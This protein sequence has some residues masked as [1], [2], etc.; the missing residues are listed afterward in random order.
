MS[1]PEQW[2]RVA[3]EDAARCR[4][5]PVMAPENSLPPF[6]IY[7]RNGTVRERV[8]VDRCRVPVATF[9]VWIH[10]ETYLE[11]K[12][13]ADEIRLGLDNFKGE[14]GGVTIQRAFLADEM[15]GEPVDFAGEGKPTYTV[16]MLFEV[17]YLEP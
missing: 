9:S 4:V 10:T 2:L 1:H 3:L 11:G 8:T 7:Q 13:L 14:A 12:R 16:Q 5:F 6:V 17:R 15:D